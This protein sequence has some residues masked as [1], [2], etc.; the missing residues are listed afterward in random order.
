M[1]AAGSVPDTLSRLSALTRL[2][3]HS[4]TFSEG[5]TLPV[6][7]MTGL[8]RLGFAKCHY[9]PDELDWWEPAREPH[10]YSNKLP[11]LT[12]LDL[13]CAASHIRGPEHM[14]P[15]CTMAMRESTCDESTCLLACSA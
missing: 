6:G 15:L 9:A 7:G 5:D 1:G 4:W 11:H 14:L 8:Q 3:L 10:D 13:R 2:E 12:A